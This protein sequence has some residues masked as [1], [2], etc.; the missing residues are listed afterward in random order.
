MQL[1]ARVTDLDTTGL[2][3]P[4]LKASCPPADTVAFAARV[5]ALDSQVP[6]RAAPGLGLVHC[7]VLSKLGLR[8]YHSRVA[9]LAQQH[10]GHAG[11]LSPTPRGLACPPQGTALQLCRQLKEA[12][13]PRGILPS[14]FTSEL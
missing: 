13:D 9:A 10:G 7:A 14:E 8:G 11:W 6:L 4:V 12:F 5:S 3:P 1:W 2:R